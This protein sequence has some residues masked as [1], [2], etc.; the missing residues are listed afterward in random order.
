MLGHQAAGVLDRHLV[1]GE[2]NHA[3]AQFEVQ[4]M[5]GSAEQGLFLADGHAALQN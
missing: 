4:R 2:G 5:Q 1:A 3:G